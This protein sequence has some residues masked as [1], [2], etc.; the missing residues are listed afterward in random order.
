MEWGLFIFIIFMILIMLY[1]TT[2]SFYCFVRKLM[3]NDIILCEGISS[4]IQGAVWK[5]PISKAV[6]GR[7]I[8][9]RYPNTKIGAL[10]IN[11]DYTGEYCG[12]FVWKYI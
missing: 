5:T 9:Y 7:L 8:G 6:T 10:T 4:T 11:T 1:K 3:G 12:S 2:M